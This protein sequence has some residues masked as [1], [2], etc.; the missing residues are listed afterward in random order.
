MVNLDGTTALVTGAGQ[1]IGR[2]IALTFALAGADIAAVDIDLGGA[3]AT[4]A[5][6]RAKGRKSL[7]VQCDV[8]SSSEVD[9]C[10]AEALAGREQ[11]HFLVNNAGIARDN[12]LIRMSDADWESVLRVNLT[13]TFNVTRAVS[14]SMIKRRFGRIVNIASVIGVMGNAGQCN[15]AA[16]K[17]G[18]IGFTR[19]IAKELAGRNINVNAIAPGFIETA[20]TASLAEQRRE[21]MR[22]LIP[23]GRFG[24]GTDVARVALFLCSELG[25]Y[26]TGQ[27][28]HCDG[29]MVMA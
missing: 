16:S 14:R 21:E 15:Y 1:G 7:A 3:E 12:L 10:V 24:S 2:D 29:G 6:V 11:I 23:L 22:R 9:R 18:I 19:A 8:A 13:G 25:S 17:A 28:I 27:V 20:M 4:A 5:L 26:V